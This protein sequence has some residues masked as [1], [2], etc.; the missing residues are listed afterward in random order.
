MLLNIYKNLNIRIMTKNDFDFCEKL[1]DLLGWGYSK[2]DFERLLSLE[3]DGCFI[4]EK[5]RKRVGMVSSIVYEK[6]AWVG[7]LVVLP[8][9]RRKGIGT[10]LTK[11]TI[12]YLKEKGVETIRLEAG[13]IS[14]LLYK[15][16]GF[17]KEMK[18]LMFCG[19]GRKIGQNN[20]KNMTEKDLE[21]IIVFD[22]LYF[23]A[24]RG[25]VLK[26]LYKDFPELCF[27]SY[28]KD[29]TGYI[30]GLSNKLGMILVGPW[31]SEKGVA[32]SLLKKMLSAAS[33]KRVYVNVPSG[34]RDCVTLLKSF[35]FKECGKMYRM[36]FGKYK[37]PGNTRGIY[38]IGPSEMG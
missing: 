1:S 33:D 14:S 26:R 3:L 30:M 31:V 34:N 2:K 12:D 7:W 28:K 23:G 25:K 9:Y 32:K 37:Y 36:Y 6:S 19:V 35:E 38:A 17:K 24:D 10:S 20:V 21:R 8:E 15:K 27:V 16:L 29:L 22:Q 13:P 5:D 4:A 18:L 11:H